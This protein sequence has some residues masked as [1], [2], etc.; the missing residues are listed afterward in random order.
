MKRLTLFISMLVLTITQMVAQD[1]SIKGT[2]TLSHQ[3]KE[4]VFK[5]NQMADAVTAAIDGDTIYLSAGNFDGDVIIDKKL[6]FIGA[7]ADEG[8]NSTNYTGKIVIKMPNNTVLTTR[9]F[10]G[11]NFVYYEY[12]GFTFLNTIENVVFKKCSGIWAF[13]LIGEI[14]SILYDRCSLEGQSF[15]S[16]IKKCIARNCD[17]SYYSMNENYQGSIIRQFFNCNIR[18][19][20]SYAGDY[21]SVLDGKYTNCII[22]NG[23]NPLYDKNNK[24]KTSSAVFTNCLFKKPEDGADI[25]N[26]A[27]VY[28]NMFYESTS[29]DDVN[30]TSM[31]KEQLQ[32]N[33][34][35]GNDGTV[36]GYFGGKN[37]YSLKIC[38]PIISYSKVHFDKDKKQVQIKMKVSP[39][40]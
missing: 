39:Q 16:N 15:D 27:S 14:K 2:I 7:G 38:E 5:Y 26:G 20:K 21:D 29:E 9:L 6:V 24:D 23:G 19:S 12:T 40:Q 10:E 37:P 36:V 33:N 35:I 4:S 31:T 25:L 28:G 22:D 8:N 11:I 18:L 13:N 17:I 34:F 3:G 1:T 30:I 32:A